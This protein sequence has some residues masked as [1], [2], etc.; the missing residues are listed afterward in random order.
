MEDFAALLEKYRPA[1]RRYVQL[2]IGPWADADDVMQ[3]I[4]LT[5]YQKFGQLKNPEAFRAWLLRIAQNKCRDY[6]REQARR[7]E[8]PLEEAA[9]PALSDGRFGPS[10]ADTVRQ[11]LDCL[12]ERD[13]QIL[14]LCYLQ[15]LP[16]AEI[17]RR[18]GIPLGTVKSRL[19]TARQ[20]FKARYPYRGPERKGEWIMKTMPKTMPP[21]RIEE[22][23]LAPFPVQ[24]E[25]LMGWF[26]VPRLGEKLTWGMYDCPSGQCSHIFDM[27]VTGKAVVHGIE[28]EELTARESACSDKDDVV[29]RT[30]VAQLTDTHCRYLA[31]IRT[32]GDVRSYIT[33]LDEEAFQ[34]NWGFGEDNCGNEIHLSPKGNIR[35]EGDR[36]TAADKP[37]LLDIVG[38]YRVTV[39]EKSYDTVCVMDVESYNSGVV[40]E[41][42]LDKN[43]RTVLWRRF[44]RDDWAME[45][46]GEPWTRQLPENQRITVNG[47]TYVH[48][49]DCITDYIL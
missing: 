13:R 2:H 5:A 37:F 14:A 45:R 39:G 22:T 47:R 4:S 10:A 35:R 46:Y 1:V 27:R 42:F 24:W 3:E 30:F 36:V 40:T 25:E 28:G 11:T 48:W 44:N 31:A 33:F 7:Q 49:Y 38:R 16:Q 17:A 12:G 8:I 18:L 15:E 34:P 19:Y 9:L 23:G 21:Y 20:N 43:G 29:E 26:L 6:F 32:D 41:Q